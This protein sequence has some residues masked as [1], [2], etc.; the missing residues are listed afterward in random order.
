MAGVEQTRSPAK[1]ITMDARTL[2]PIIARAFVSGGVAIAGL[3][4][5]AGIAH[6]HHH[7]RIRDYEGGHGACTSLTQCRNTP[8]S[9]WTAAMADGPDTPGD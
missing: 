5:G 3:V 6:A 7:V 4:L 8:R 2:R 9:T 1:G